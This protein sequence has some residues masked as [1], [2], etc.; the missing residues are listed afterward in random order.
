MLLVS[1]FQLTSSAEPSS[2]ISHQGLKSSDKTSV[3]TRRNPHF[4]TGQN[5]T[6]KI[7]AHQPMDIYYI[8]GMCP[9]MSLGNSRLGG[10]RGPPDNVLAACDLSWPRG[11][12]PTAP[13][14]PPGLRPF[15]RLATGPHGKGGGSGAAGRGPEGRE[16]TGGQQDPEWPS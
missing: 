15:T 1:P 7:L 12:R 14:C 11:P 16:V 3:V 4:V 5:K 9:G 6:S 13:G 10:F 8:S 2:I